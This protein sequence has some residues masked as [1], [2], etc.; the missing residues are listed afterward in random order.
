MRATHLL[1]AGHDI[2]FN[3][4]PAVRPGDA[5]AGKH[6]RPFRTCFNPRPAV[7]PGDAA[8]DGGLHVAQLVSIRARP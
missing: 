7:R 8:G 4:R 5:R 1:E 6:A 3:P 2:R